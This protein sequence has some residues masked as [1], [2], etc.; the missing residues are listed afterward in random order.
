[1]LD[2]L[3]ELAALRCPAGWGASPEMPRGSAQQGARR[4]ALGVVAGGCSSPGSGP[5][6]RSRGTRPTEPRSSARRCSPP[7]STCPSMRG[8]PP[9]SNEPTA[10]ALRV[11]HLGS[12][13]L[14]SAD[15]PPG[16]GPALA[17]RLRWRAD[18]EG[19][20]RAPARQQALPFLPITSLLLLA[21][22]VKGERSDSRSDT[23]CP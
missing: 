23:Q 7:A 18:Y 10:P 4:A 11:A 15:V 19:P 9:T 22:T 6:R 5:A 12:P 14:H 17:E 2:A 13:G 16:H 20:R 21:P 3:L 8:M 1:M